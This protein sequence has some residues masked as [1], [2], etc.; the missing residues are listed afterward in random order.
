M[1]SLFFATGQ[2][3]SSRVQPLDAKEQPHSESL[4]SLEWQ[5]RLA[6]A[7]S[8]CALSGCVVLWLMGV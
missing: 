8:L 5:A 2:V 4:L 1:H 3:I 7:L 6:I